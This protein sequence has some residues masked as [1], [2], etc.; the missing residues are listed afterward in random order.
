MEVI[1]VKR[2]PAVGAAMEEQVKWQ[3]Q[4][5]NGTHQE[6]TAHLT[7]FAKSLSTFRS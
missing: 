2:G 5:P 4:F 1:N 3:L 7:E 6:L